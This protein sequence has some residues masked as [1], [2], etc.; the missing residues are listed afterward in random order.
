MTY[1]LHKCSV[2]AWTMEFASRE[3]ARTELLT[4]ICGLCLRGDEKDG[5]CPDVNDINS[6]LGTACGCEYDYEEVAE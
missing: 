2:P 6:L 3:D 4:H 1:I 5:D